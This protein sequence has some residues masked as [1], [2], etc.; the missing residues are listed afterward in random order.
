MVNTTALTI[1]FAGV[2]RAAERLEALGEALVDQPCVHLIAGG[3]AP[4]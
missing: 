3:L 1:A 2:T 4:E